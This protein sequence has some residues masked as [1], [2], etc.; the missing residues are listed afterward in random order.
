MPAKTSDWTKSPQFGPANGPF[1]SVS[2]ITWRR[3]PVNLVNLV[4]ETKLPQVFAAGNKLYNKIEDED[5]PEILKDSP[6][7]ITSVKVSSPNKKRVSPPHIC[8]PELASN[9]SV[10]LRSGRK[11]ILKSV[12]SFPPLIPCTGIKYTTSQ[13]AN[14]HSERSDK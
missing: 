10:G 4:G 8:V 6:A 3:S 14:A 5:T 2:N 1:S 7:P 13:P 12:P 11:F 9:S